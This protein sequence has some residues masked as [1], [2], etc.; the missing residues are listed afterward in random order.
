MRT[1]G[2][3]KKSTA[4]MLFFDIEIAPIIGTTWATYDTNVIWKIQDWYILC[5]AYKWQGEKK[6][7]VVS[8]PQ[9]K[10][11][12]PGSTDDREIVE[13]LHQLFDEAHI[14][15][16]HNGN[17]F[18]IKKVNARFLIHGLT[19]PSDYQKIDTL[20]VARR[21]FGFTSNKLDELGATLGV[22]RKEHSDKELWRLCM[23]GEPKAW[24]KMEKYNKQDVV[25]LEA[26]Y[27]KLLPYDTTHPN[28]ALITNRPKACP[29]CGVERQF[30]SHGKRYTKTSVMQTWQCKACASVFRTRLADRIQKPDYV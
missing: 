4:R 10:G 27:N 13:K 2:Q 3:S 28:M 24:R 19:P 18:D 15:V 5:F 23:A 17:Y 30:V 1:G 8:Q 6:T 26:V 29:R 12:T 7:H 21:N 16:A 11:Y 20:L 22:G 9:F 25:L 14:V